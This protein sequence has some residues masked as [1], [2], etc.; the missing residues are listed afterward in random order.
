[1]LAE[2]E[3]VDRAVAQT[4]I[5]T[6]IRAE[7][8]I[9]LPQSPREWI[10]EQ[11][12]KCNVYIGIYSHRYGW[13]IPEENVSATEF[14]FNFARQLKKPIL[15]WIR[16]LREGEKVLPDFERQKQFLSRVSDFSE[17]YLRQEF[18]E[19]NNLELWVTTALQKTF[20]EIISRV[21]SG[22]SSSEV[23]PN[24]ALVAAYL[25]EIIRQK[26]YA[27]WGDETY[28]DRTISQTEDLFARTVTPYGKASKPEPLEE[29]LGRQDKLVLLG[30]PGL[31]KT[32][33]LLHL[34][35]AAATCA[36]A[37]PASIAR[38]GFH[39]PIY[40]ELKYYD[41]EKEL[42]LLLARRV[43]DV[44]RP[45]KIMIAPDLTESTR[46]M[47]TWLAQPDARFLFLL[48]GL[49]EVRPEFHTEIRGL[50]QSV[51][52]YPHKVV[53]SCRE[54]DYDQSL[55]HQATAFVLQGLQTD[56]IR[57][58]LRRALGEKSRWLFKNQIRKDERMRTLAANPLMLWLISVIA[59]DNPKARL[60]ANRG[61]LLQQFVERMPKLR[62]SEG[63]RDK[64]PLHV[65]TE[66]L[67]KLGAE[68]Q[69]RGWLSASPGEA[70]SWQYSTAG[71]RPEDVLVQAK[72]WRF[73]KADGTT[74]EP[75]EFL[76]Q[77]FLEYFAAVNLD[78]QVR[79]NLNYGGVLHGQSVSKEWEE[80][81]TML[82]GISKR[83]AELVKW[84]S[85]YIVE[86]KQWRAVELV[87][88][89]WES[90]DA[91]GDPEAR[92]AVITALTA[93]LR[94]GSEYVRGRTAY[95]LG[96]IGGPQVIPPLIAAL[97]DK[98]IKVR[99]ASAKVVG[100]INSPDIVNPLIALLKDGDV[101]ARIAAIGLLVKTRYLQ[102]IEPIIAMLQDKDPRVRVAVVEA[103]QKIPDSSVIEPLFAAVEDENEDV[104]NHAACALE[105]EDDPRVINFFIGA[106]SDKDVRVRR[107][108]AATLVSKRDVPVTSTLITAAIRDEDEYVR[109]HASHILMRIGSSAVEPLTAELNDKRAKVRGKV[110]ELLGRIDDPR[111][112]EPI[113]AALEDESIYVR[114]RAT[115][116]LCGVND[117]L[118]IEPLIALLRN[119]DPSLSQ[120]AARALGRIGEPAIYSLIVL[121]KDKD[122][123]VRCGA[124]LALRVLLTSRA[125]GQRF[126]ES[127]TRAAVG[128]HIIEPL[129]AALKDDD[130]CVR[131]NT[132]Y[133]LE[134]IDD[135]QV[136]EA[137]IAVLQDRAVQVRAAAV[138]S[139]GTIRDE[140][141][142]E[143]LIAALS[144][145][146]GEVRLNA[147]RC[148]GEIGGERTI[149]PLIN[150][151]Q[152]DYVSMYED[153]DG[154]DISVR[155]LAIQA[156]GKSRDKRAVKP[157]A[158]IL[159]EEKD[160][161]TRLWIAN[162]LSEI[163]D[164]HAKNILV[165]M[166]DQDE[167]EY[168]RTN[169]AEMLDGM[170]RKRSS[171]TK[172][173]I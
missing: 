164:T 145:D 91:F 103:L 153:F 152:D 105:K 130:T 29:V 128:T 173:L 123:S 89:C 106:L 24:S 46:V 43:N 83:P 127:K 78:A 147:V 160:Y 10:K 37:L 144:D 18:D 71:Y 151:L 23:H 155:V 15:V 116:S 39:I 9:S 143:P 73:L 141:V 86:Q 64:I 140:R 111:V 138:T 38:Y 85:T 110:I 42:E 69:E 161:V 45:R 76:H 87:V 41:G 40:V 81:I 82:A 56:E 129:V 98:D 4:E 117:P 94:H 113:I 62:R 26:P 119:T 92:S 104:R 47:K 95:A 49:N 167:D 36:A 54:R 136:V 50:L 150:A 121:L 61:K 52:S 34:A 8:E 170:P 3:C 67:M 77:L 168:V 165:A 12:E 80:T 35:W 134:G 21:T 6:G 159:R 59:Q 166:R 133:A 16:K 22:H 17:G 124:A 44:L 60:P 90:S 7:T 63:L 93:A 55:Y 79:R 48:D 126:V 13:V 120:R 109:Q 1:M 70:Y 58:Y 122:S 132:A 101:E 51:L 65:V 157:L 102:V 171:A 33:S 11:V 156:L 88:R 107:H 53:I 158:A 99:R 19:L 27:L 66:T 20:V 169:A 25:E 72:E 57:K 149:M 162:S 163:G 74:G 14:E 172:R 131:M 112:A 5:A 137:L 2:R 28:I 96:N 108:A 100:V 118:A 139:L 114:R 142:V 84:L 146:E 75:V 30:E 135:L 68:M 31:G 115:D 148:L 97:Q 154:N 32:T 125:V